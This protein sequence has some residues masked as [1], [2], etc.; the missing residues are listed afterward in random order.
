MPDVTTAPP[1]PNPPPPPHAPQG[2]KGRI[3][4]G[5]QPTGNLHLGNYLGAIRNF[6]RLQNDYECLYCVVAMHAITQ[7]QDPGLLASQTREIAAAFLAAG[8]DGGK[9]ITFN[10]SMVPAHAQL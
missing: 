3:L 7:P 8:V 2:L 4:S 10:R 9:H 5:V 6:A 1:P